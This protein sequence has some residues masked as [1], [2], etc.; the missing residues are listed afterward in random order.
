M[1]KFLIVTLALLS[2]TLFCYACDQGPAN[3]GCGTTNPIPNPNPN[4]GVCTEDGGYVDG[5]IESKLYYPC[6]LPNSS[7]RVGATTVTGGFWEVLEDMEWLSESIADAGYVTLAFTV[8]NNTGLLRGW[9]KSH[10]G[11]IARLKAINNDYSSS[12]YGKIDES[13]LQ[14]CGHSKG[15]GSSLWAAADDLNGLLKTCVG[16][17]PWQ[18]IQPYENYGMK[19]ITAATL[20]QAAANDS[21]A[22]P[23]MTRALY[24][25]PF[26]TTTLPGQGLPNT[27]SKA[28]YEFQGQGHAAWYQAF[29]AQAELFSKNLIAWM[30]YYLDGDTSYKSQLDADGAKCVKFEWIDKSGSTGWNSSGSGSSGSGSVW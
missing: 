18:E 23:S 5:A 15:G 26:A 20:I 12:L 22:V 11:A 30:K 3:G 4:V 13:K 29:P 2:V 6:D 1:K 21:M 19:R 10:I 27:I 9:K 14:T 24:G 17:A 28:Y 25:Q 7:R 16:M 8:Q